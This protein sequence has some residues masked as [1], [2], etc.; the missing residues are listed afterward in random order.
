M[1]LRGV[2]AKGPRLERAAVA[3]VPPPRQAQVPVPPMGAEERTKRP[4][5]EPAYVQLAGVL[6]SRDKAAYVCSP[7]WQPWKVF[8]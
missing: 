5:L 3:A 1:Q 8:N 7:I 4:E 2:N 6:R